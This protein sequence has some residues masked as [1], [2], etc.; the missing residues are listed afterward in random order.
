MRQNRRRESAPDYRRLRDREPEAVKQW[1]LA[2]AEAMYTFVFYRV[3]KQEDLAADVVQETF[4]VALERIEDFDESRGAMLAWLQ[5][6][7]RNCIRRALRQQA[8]CRRHLA[9]WQTLD[10]KLFEVY[11]RMTESSLPDEIVQRQE[12]TELVQVTFAHL[13]ENYRQ[14]LKRHYYEDRSLKEIAR[15]QGL[16]VSAVK[17]LLYRAR[18]AF[19]DIFLSFA[20]SMSDGQREEGAVL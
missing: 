3:A 1:F 10:E 6:T 14:V 2:Y 11:R 7:A 8:R 13:P 19:K 5:Y 15:A 20:E 17:S 9:Q 16:T 4:L 18:L 12:T